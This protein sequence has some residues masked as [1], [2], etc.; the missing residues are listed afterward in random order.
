MTRVACSGPQ[1]SK[2]VPTI[3]Y[4]VHGTVAPETCNTLSDCTLWKLDGVETAI[5]ARILTVVL[6]LRLI[7]LVSTVPRLDPL[8]LKQVDKK[9]L[10]GGK[11]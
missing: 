8:F 11:T 4:E 7:C 3:R 10:S 6:R 5:S 1:E 2:K 9:T